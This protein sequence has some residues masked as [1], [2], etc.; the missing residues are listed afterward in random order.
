MLAQ[1][2]GGLG[3]PWSGR[4]KGQGLK[5]S[6]LPLEPHDGA[7]DDS[8]VSLTCRAGRQR[9]PTCPAVLRKAPGPHEMRS[10]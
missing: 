8:S 10:A 2:A 1:K 5:L 9:R 3:P 6:K 7:D 4:G